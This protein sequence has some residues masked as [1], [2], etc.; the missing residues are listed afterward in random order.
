M[1]HGIDMEVAN[2]RGHTPFDLATDP[3]IRKL[4]TKSR[5]QQNCSGTKCGKAKF[6]FQNTQFYCQECDK[7]FCK[8]CCT[9][10]R[11]FENVDSEEKEKTVCRCEDC[12]LTITEGEQR[13]RDAMNTG[14]YATLDRVF[15]EIL[16]MQVDIDIKLKAE[17]EKLHLRLEKE[18]DIRNFMSSVKH[19]DIY[20][21]IRKSVKILTDKHEEAERLGVALD[22]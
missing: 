11:V 6:S 19:N 18:L 10:S 9:R 5:Q 3:E 16:Q 14:D 22:P 15:K 12:Q 7:F 4:I 13:L 1:S 17:A 20:K 2:D 8:K 21:T